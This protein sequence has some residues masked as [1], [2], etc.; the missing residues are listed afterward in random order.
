MK[1]LLVLY[2]SRSGNTEK[3]A[4]AVVEGAQSIEGVKV[5]L[6]YHVESQELLAFDAIAVGAPTY[7]HVMPLDFKNLFEE[8][9]SHG[10]SLKGKIGA[11]FGSYG[12]SGE[13]PKLVLDIMQ[14][15]FDMQIIESPVV[16]K[17]IPNEA[18]IDECINL[19]KKL[20][21]TL[22]NSA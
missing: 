16:A 14:T 10:I 5:E 4:K 1:K 19:G 11:A 18:A 2:Y 13:A 22:M 15:K 9:T 12:W 21:E 20:A 3:M 7:R 8:A 17:Y 6:K